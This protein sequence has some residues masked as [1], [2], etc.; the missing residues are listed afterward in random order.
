MSCTC[1][2]GTPVCPYCWSVN[3]GPYPPKPIV[4]QCEDCVRLFTKP[5][6]ISDAELASFVTGAHNQ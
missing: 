3:I 2:S 1:T 4:C 6:C 5:Y